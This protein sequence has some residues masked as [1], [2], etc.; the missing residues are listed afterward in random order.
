MLT[1]WWSCRL[2]IA[3]IIVPAAVD[4]EVRCYLCMPAEELL[5]VLAVEEGEAK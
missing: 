5:E 1:G 2:L 3:A 4:D